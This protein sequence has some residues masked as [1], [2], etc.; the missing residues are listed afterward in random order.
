[1]R[2]VAK[3]IIGSGVQTGQRVGVMSRTRYEWTLVDFAIWYAGCVS[4][5]I[6]E[7]KPSSIRCRVVCRT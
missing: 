2:A 5:P 1:V 4:V 3:G 6:Y 7:T